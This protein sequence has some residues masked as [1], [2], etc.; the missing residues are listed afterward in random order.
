MS[1]TTVLAA[2][3][4]RRFFRR[5]VRAF[6]NGACPSCGDSIDDHLD[7]EADECIRT[8]SY[9]TADTLVEV[10]DDRRKGR[11]A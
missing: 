6:F 1:I 2:R 3:D 9:W 5:A 10:A 8:A 4:G 7:S 11:A